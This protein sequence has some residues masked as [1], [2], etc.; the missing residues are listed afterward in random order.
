MNSEK[1]NYLGN[2]LL[3]RANVPMD[4]SEEQ[5]EEYVKCSKNPI[6]FI[7]NYI[8]IVNVDEG[9]VPF[10]LWEF[11]EDM[12][13]KFNDNRFVICKMPRQTGK[14]TT[15]IAYLLHFVLYNQDV[16]VGILANKGVTAR[17]LLGRWKLAYENLPMWL[18]QGVVEWNKGNIELENGSKILASA[19]S[20]SAIRGGTFNIIMLDEFAFV[21][22]NIA[23]E[24]FRSV[25]PTISSGNTTKVLI[26]STPNGMN[27]FYKMWT[28]AV[29]GRSDYLPIDV[30]WSEVPG[31]D[32]KW[33]EQTIRNT[34]EDQFRIEFETE[35]IGSTNTLISPS[36][37][38]KL[39]YK[40]PIAS[41]DGYDVWEKAQDGRSYF[42]ACDVARGAGKDFSAFSVIDITDTPYR[43]VARYMNNQIS[44]LLY[45]TVIAKVAQDYNEAH[46]LLEVNDIG[47]Q[48]AD[49]LHYDLEYE[50]ILTS[51]TKGRSGQVLSAG[52]S[53]GTDLGIKTT[54]QVK[55]I[56]CRV[57][58]NLIEEDQLLIPDLMAIAELSCFA[59]KGKSYAATEGAHDD[60]VMSLVLFAWVANQRYFKD[61]MDQD[62]RLQMYQERMREIEEDLTPFGFIE[63]GLEN[64]IIV[65]DSG[66][67]WNVVKDHGYG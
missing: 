50:N 52:F 12:I 30:H 4:F 3:K 8:Q 49:T 15:I 19:T 2:P 9:L 1:F 33:K 43:M 32:K 7:K 31:R 16:R 11:Q 61:L 27:Q 17:E 24:F 36:K 56:G 66:Q 48:V 5:I 67:S 23:E 21:P 57:L 55:R 6:H 63:S 39:V 42:M 47:G 62:L 64:E 60:I 26:V 22:D 53:K 51:T 14:S 38:T 58:K 28:D 13:N 18:Q 37:L 10:D 29:E 59:I 45:P 46:V 41:K 25:Y 34:S 20:S 54:A 35:F 65:D 44:P 40:N